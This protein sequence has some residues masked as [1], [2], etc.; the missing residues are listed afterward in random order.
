MKKTFKMAMVEGSGEI[1]IESSFKHFGYTFVI[2][3]AFK[4]DYWKVSEYETGSSVGISENKTA[5]AKRFAI[6]KLSRIGQKRFKSIVDG[7]I[8]EHGII[9]E[10]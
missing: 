3:R 4:D 5:D 9:N 1:E 6:E 2:H 8:K 7:F 10:S